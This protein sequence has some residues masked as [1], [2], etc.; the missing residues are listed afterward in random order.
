MSQLVGEFT[1]ETWFYVCISE[2]YLNISTSL[3]A[4]GKHFLA[5]Y[6]GKFGFVLS[7]AV[8]IMTQTAIQRNNGSCNNLKN[9]QT[10]HL[11]P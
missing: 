10:V 9:E 4:H 6:A 3:K 2:I 11:T 7:T 5:E 8:G 1:P